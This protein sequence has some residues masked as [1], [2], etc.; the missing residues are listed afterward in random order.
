MM[1]G[2]RFERKETRKEAR[3]VGA[4]SV[5]VGRVERVVAKVDRTMPAGR[6]MKVG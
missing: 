2:M 1:G 3:Q 5:V 4:D 6:K